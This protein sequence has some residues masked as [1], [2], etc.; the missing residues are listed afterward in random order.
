MN[1][2]LF[3]M[4]GYKLDNSAESAFAASQRRRFMRFPPDPLDT[5]LVDFKGGATFEPEFVGLIRQEAYAGCGLLL[6]FQDGM[7]TAFLKGRRCTIKV[8][9]LPPLPAEIVWAV[10]I[11]DEALKVGFKFDE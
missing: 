7:E 9:K 6:A 4:R 8:G 1:V 3:E 2:N 5:A 10:I 11:D